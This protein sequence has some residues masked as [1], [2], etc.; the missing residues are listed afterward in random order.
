M[1]FMI[2]SILLLVLILFIYG[3]NK[4][5]VTTKNIYSEKITNE[6]VVVQISDTHNKEMFPNN[7]YLLNICKNANPDI[8]VHTGDL[9]RTNE[10]LDNTKKLIEELTKIAP[11]YAV[12]G[13]HDV[14]NGRYN[15]IKECLNSYNV[16]VLENEELFLEE[17]NINFVGLLNS[18]KKEIKFIDNYSIDENKYNVCLIHKP[19]NFISLEYDKF[20][21]FLCGHTHGGQ[22]IIPFIGSLM[23]SDRKMFPGKWYGEKIFN[24]TNGYI[25]RGIGGPQIPPR[26]NNHPEICVYHFLPEKSS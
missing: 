26:F 15:E 2:I 23:T 4:I 9:I 17:N 13:N 21:F 8:I 6:L 5:D 18:L 3:N 25:N 11:V 16:T 12:Q 7:S 14:H 19:E 20:D 22:W 24:K 1:I 10:R